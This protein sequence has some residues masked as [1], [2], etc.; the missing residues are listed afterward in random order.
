MERRRASRPGVASKLHCS[1]A[2]SSGASFLSS[3]G[4]CYIVCG[5]VYHGG[6][7]T[8]YLVGLLWELNK[9]PGPEEME[10]RIWLES[11][12]VRTGLSLKRQEIQN[13]LQDWI[14]IKQDTGHL[15][16]INK[17]WGEQSSSGV[18][19]PGSHPQNSVSI[20]WS[21]WTLARRKRKPKG[22]NADPH[23]S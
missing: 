13:I 23:S 17:V 7:T 19:S 21:T 2:L 14:I 8:T 4:L 12:S 5:G 3:L 18:M 16:S 11:V 9:L 6:S 22:R 10:R 1:R 20:S 15:S